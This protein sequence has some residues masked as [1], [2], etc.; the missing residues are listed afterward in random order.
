[1]RSFAKA[2]RR[3]TPRSQR[4]PNFLGNAQFKEEFMK[5]FITA[6]QERKSTMENEIL[7]GGH[8]NYEEMT[9]SIFKMVEDHLRS[10]LTTRLLNQ[11]GWNQIAFEKVVQGL[12][13]EVRSIF[14]GK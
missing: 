2:S 6:L 12:K 14:Y 9:Q 11:Q 10:S 4:E 5:E 8:R 7:R 3:V 1:M 13:T